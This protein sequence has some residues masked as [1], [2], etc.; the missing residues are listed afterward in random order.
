MKL[1]WKYY[2]G[3]Q[4]TIS[5][6]GGGG[7][8]GRWGSCDASEPIIANGIVYMCSEFDHSSVALDAK[9]G[10]LLWK[11]DTVGSPS[12]AVSDGIIYGG[13][14]ARPYTFWA[15]DA[16]TG[17]TKW[18]YQYG[19]G[20]TI[21][22]PVVSNEIVYN[23]DSSVVCALDAK[24]GE[25][26]W[27]SSLCSYPFPA[28]VSEGIIYSYSSSSY[29]RID[30]PMK[31]WE[32]CALNDKTGELMW[33]SSFSGNIMPYI[34]TLSLSDGILYVSAGNKLYA[35]DAKRGGIKWEFE[36]NHSVSPP[37]ILKDSIYVGSVYEGIYAL[38]S[39]T[40]KIK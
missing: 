8:S 9:T 40:G 2:V 14:L 24:T 12:L 18:K 27:T 32:I 15:L 30:I 20:S 1:L 23:T 36:S 26:L 11:N 4:R 22:P 17:E 6:G 19:V 31:N 33:K 10:K 16:K 25:K 37:A 7:W 29:G 28:A 21:D 3:P 5:Y 35:L 34:P 13:A 39:K 38:D